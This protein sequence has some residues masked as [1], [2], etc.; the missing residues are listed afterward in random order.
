MLFADSGALLGPFAEPGEIQAVCNYRFIFKK[1][2]TFTLHLK[3]LYARRR[4]HPASISPQ[5]A[6]ASGKR[7]PGR[8]RGEP[9][10]LPSAPSHFRQRLPT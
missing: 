8:R 2:A 4:L 6:P 5:P 1:I 9:S 3:V 10:L 7:G